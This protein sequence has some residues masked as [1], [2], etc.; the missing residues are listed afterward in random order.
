MQIL[1]PS[2]HT[3]GTTAAKNA[4]NDSYRHFGRY[5]VGASAIFGGLVLLIDKTPLLVV[6]LVY[7]LLTFP[8]F[9]A[10][11]KLS[12]TRNVFIFSLG[13]LYVVTLPVS[14]FL[15]Q[16]LAGKQ[17]V[18]WLLLTVWGIKVVES[19]FDYFLGQG[20]LPLYKRE[21]K[22][23][24]GVLSAFAAAPVMALLAARFSGTDLT[25][26]VMFGFVVCGA[27]MLGDFI[28]DLLRA[29]ARRLALRASYRRRFDSILKYFDGLMLS[30]P[31]LLVLYL[32]DIL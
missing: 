7:F 17:L 30:A 14:L 18:E 23:F 11:D 25:S 19:V 1:P 8:L 16:V 27:M 10:W 5:L 31:L 24:I 15:L 3:P 32:L 12:R 2:S 6:A 26:P 28:E 9:D 4:N 20:Q 29:R 21:D 13:I 22:S